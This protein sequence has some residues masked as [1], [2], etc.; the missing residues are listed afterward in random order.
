MTMT[1]L[2]VLF[3]LGAV[4]CALVAAFA[5]PPRPQ[6]LAL[7]VALVAAALAVPAVRALQ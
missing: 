3:L 1:V 4:V 7:A 6:M 2:V 5:P